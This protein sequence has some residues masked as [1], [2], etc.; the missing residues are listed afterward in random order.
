[1]LS[2][3]LSFLDFLQEH[4]RNA[5]LDAVVPTLT[6]LGDYGILWILLTVGLLAFPK[7]RRV[8]LA[9]ACALLLDLLLCNL[10]L[11]PLVARE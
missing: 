9:A 1:M 5:F 7:T 2:F 4:L 3:E 8:G 11:K 10:L 6:K